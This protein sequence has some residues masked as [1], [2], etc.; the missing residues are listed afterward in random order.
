MEEHRYWKSYNVEREEERGKGTI[1]AQA[2]KRD[3][4]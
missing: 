3:E 2:N 1:I 4:K